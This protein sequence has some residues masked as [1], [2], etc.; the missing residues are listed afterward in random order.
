MDPINEKE[1]FQ[2]VNQL[3]IEFFHKPF[4]HYVKFNH[5][6]RTTGGRYLPQTNV[7][8]LNPKYV[9]EMDIEEFK[10]IIK[11]ELCHYHLHIEGKGYK[12][13][14]LEFKQLLVETGSPRH[15]KPLPSINRTKHI[16]R[17]EKCNYI[18]E[19]IKRVNINRYRCGKCKGKL[20]HIR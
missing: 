16:Y 7:I 13:G 15:C 12:H 2:L 14:D 17:C 19:R 5:R 18:Y 10:G 1:L 9:T 20:V 3:S 6:L 8:E 4:K 11:H